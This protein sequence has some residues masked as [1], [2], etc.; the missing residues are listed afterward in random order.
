MSALRTLTSFRD[1]FKRHDLHEGFSDPASQEDLL[2]LPGTGLYASHDTR[3]IV[4]FICFSL[5]H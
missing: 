1:Q 3:H 2:T 4:A 5:C